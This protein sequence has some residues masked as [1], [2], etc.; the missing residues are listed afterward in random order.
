MRGSP[1]TGRVQFQAGRVLQAE[2]KDALLM[3]IRQLANKDQS[4]RRIAARSEVGSRRRVVLR[5][6]IRGSRLARRIRRTASA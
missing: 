1:Q 2:P 4:H 5:N 3:P 6:W